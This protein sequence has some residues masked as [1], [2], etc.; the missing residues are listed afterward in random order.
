MRYLANKID[1]AIHCNCVSWRGTRLGYLPGNLAVLPDPV[2]FL[3][4]AMLFDTLPCCPA[5]LTVSVAWL[6]D[7]FVRRLIE[8]SGQSHLS[9][10]SG[11]CTSARHL[12][13]APLCVNWLRSLDA[14][15]S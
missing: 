6:H 1:Y 9:V 5:V 14:F 8:L 15:P 13:S 12:A 3:G 4:W 11:C 10:S 7:V 2:G